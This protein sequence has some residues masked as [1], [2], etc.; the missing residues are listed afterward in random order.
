MNIKIHKYFILLEKYLFAVI[1][2]K[3]PSPL[4]LDF[5]PINGTFNLNE[6]YMFPSPLGHDFK[7]A[8]LEE[9]PRLIVYFHP[10][11]GLI[12]N[13]KKQEMKIIKNRSFHP[14][15]GLIL[16]MTQFEEINF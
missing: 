4:G 7:R 14:L 2:E 3:F 9:K 10:L 8:M 16:N 12:L 11:W 13:L 6:A 15:W 5:K 1:K